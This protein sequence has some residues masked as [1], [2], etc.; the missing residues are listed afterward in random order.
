M[1]QFTEFSRKLGDD[2]IAWARPEGWG[3]GVTAVRIFV[4]LL[5]IS[6]KSF[7]IIE[8]I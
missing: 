8:Y 3:P 4:S 6:C 5:R 2:I 1:D 7:N